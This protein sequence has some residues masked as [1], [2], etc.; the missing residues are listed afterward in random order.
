V[1][2]AGAGQQSAHARKAGSVFALEGEA[3][4]LAD[5][6]PDLLVEAMRVS[7][8]VAH[9]IHGRRRAGP[10]ETFWQFRQF[11]SNDAATLVDWR[12]SASSDHL[13]VREREWEAAH[14]MWLWPDLSPSMDFRSELSQVTKRERAVVLMLA[15]AELLVRGGERV[16]LLGLSRPTASRKATTKLAETLAQSMGQPGLDESLPPGVRLSRFSGVLLFSDFLDPLEVVTER[17]TQLAG[18][19]VSG[20]LVQ[21]MDPAEETLPYQGR[22][23]FLGMEGDHRWLADRV[24]TLRPQYLARLKAHRAGLE[25]LAA[26]LG[27]SF[28]VHHTDRPPAEPLLTLIMRLQNSGRDYRWAQAGT[29]AGEAG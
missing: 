23:E 6:L 9:G 2:A 21:V 15:A 26:K 25:T 18:D 7:S 19:G 12:R 5:R 22:T 24:E 3:H 13:Y 28:L 14:T 29:A 10:G 17:L 11:Q 16:A 1:A 8:T 27:W 20:H 4:G